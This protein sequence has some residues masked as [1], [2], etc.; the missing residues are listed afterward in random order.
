MRSTAIN[1]VL[2]AALATGADGDDDQTAA[3]I[4][5]AAITLEEVDAAA[6]GR[7]LA[8]RSQEYSVRSHALER[9]IAARLLAQAAAERGLSVEELSRIE[10]EGKAEAVTAE[11]TRAAY[12]AEAA[13]YKAL[14]EPDALKAVET[15]L[16]RQS[17]AR[18][19]EAFLAE[20]RRKAGV[21]VYLEAPRVAVSSEGP[22]HGLASAPV[23]I[24]VFSDFQCPY[25]ARAVPVLDALGKRF[26]DAVR[27]VYRHFPLSNHTQA[28]KAA[29]A[30]ACAQEQG[31]FW[32]MHDRLFANQQRLAGPDLKQH[33]KELGLDSVAFDSCLDSGRLA[34]TWRRDLRDGQKYGVSGTPAFFVNGRFASGV[35]TLAAFADVVSEEIER[36]GRRGGTT[37]AR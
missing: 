9:L 8:I 19:R 1:L 3:R 36:A 15:N 23:T 28:A 16:R 14:S 25:C 29:E 37:S 32:E 10:I 20:L 4:G 13:R 12:Q 22:A 7:L 5:A 26:G 17:I 27:V 33:A 18:R 24:V 30:A 31:R 11:A 2:L 34:E 35:Q 6:G 21:V